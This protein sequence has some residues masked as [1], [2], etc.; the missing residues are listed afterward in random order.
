MVEELLLKNN[1]MKYFKFGSGSKTMVMVPGLSVKS[2]CDYEN[3]IIS[4]YKIFNDEFTIYCFDRVDKPVEGYTINDLANDLL[5]AI[6]LLNLK[7]IYLFGASQG[8]MIS[9][10]LT[11]NHPNLFKKLVVQLHLVLEIDLIKIYLTG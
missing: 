9:F 8:G 11:I 6:T 2:V 4:D 7:D 10:T 1:K 5:E 3:N